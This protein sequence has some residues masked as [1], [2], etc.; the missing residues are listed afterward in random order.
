MGWIA[1][2]TL[3]EIW[4]CTSPGRNGP[5]PF[6]LSSF[7]SLVPSPSRF[8]GPDWL[9][10]LP[11]EDCTWLHP[12]PARE[13]GV[14]SHQRFPLQSVAFCGLFFPPS[15]GFLWPPSWTLFPYSNYLTFPFSRDRRPSSLGIS[16][17][18]PLWLLPAEL[19]LRGVL[20]SLVI[21]RPQ[22]P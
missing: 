2:S 10:P 16:V 4:E 14:F 12:R 8:L 21:F 1:S 11:T 9:Q 20:G 7:I 22:G 19:G 6:W 18:K 15:H 3:L 5:V 13:G 17:S